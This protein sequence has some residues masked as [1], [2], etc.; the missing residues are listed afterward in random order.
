MRREAC[1]ASRGEEQA[2]ADGASRESRA[3]IE[4]RVGVARRRRTGG[5]CEGREN[6]SRSEWCECRCCCSFYFALA[7]RTSAVDSL[8]HSS[9]LSRRRKRISAEVE[10]KSLLRET[11]AACV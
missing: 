1:V 2:P 6:R 4:G 8:F 3:R 11:S 5:T 10:S 7:T 9:L